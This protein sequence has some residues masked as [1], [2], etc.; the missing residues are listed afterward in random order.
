MSFNP[1][2]QTHVCAVGPGV[3]KHFRYSEA[4]FK[5]FAFQKTEPLN[6]TCHAWANAEQVLVG[7]ESGRIQLMEAGELKQE[8]L[9]T[10]FVNTGQDR[11]SRSRSIGEKKGSGYDRQL[12]ARHSVTFL[13]LRLAFIRRSVEVLS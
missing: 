8:F 6:Y 12:M 10:T 4:T 9:V 11:G 7:S 1:E 2:D 13:S 5:Q 3:C